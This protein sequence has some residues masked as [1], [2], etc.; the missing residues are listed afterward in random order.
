MVHP[1]AVKPDGGFRFISIVQ[2]CAVWATY[3]AKLIG[4][5]D[6]QVWFA[7]QEMV[8]RRCLAIK[9]GQRIAYTITELHELTE[10][11][12]G[13]ASL[14]R[15]AHYGLLTW[16]ADTIAFPLNPHLAGQQT[17][18]SDMLELVR[19]CKR[20]VPVPRRMLRFL[21][22]GCSRVMV[23]TVLGHLFRCLYYRKGECHPA[24]LCKA[25]WVAEVFGVSERAVK[26]ARQGLEALGWLERIEIKQWVRNRYGQKMAINLYWEVPAPYQPVAESTPKIA[27]LPLPF[28]PEIAPPDSN[29]KLPTENENNQKPVGSVPP[30][31]LTALF[32]EERERMRNGTAP[33]QPVERVV[34]CSSSASDKQKQ[35][36]APRPT[37][38]LAAPSLTNVVLEDLRDTERLFALYLQAIAATLL[39]KSE[40]EQLAFFALA[41]HVLAYKPTNPGG[42]FRQ[43]L[44]RKQFQVITQEEEDAA[45]R[46]LKQY[47]YGRDVPPS[48]PERERCTNTTKEITIKAA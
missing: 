18:L 28:S 25:S 15:L 20:Q 6:L 7:A 46:R 42:L 2:L 41:Q 33:T 12:G 47:R 31:V 35:G 45:V 26:T 44:T 9:R 14:K 36:V 23:A 40:A 1:S 39:G 4:P 16:T 5:F 24:G 8:A 3:H 37:P 19:N 21:A 17:R 48:V 30:G 11:E 27:P 38:V 43:L 29:R 34:M 10:R 32:T 13:A 22:R